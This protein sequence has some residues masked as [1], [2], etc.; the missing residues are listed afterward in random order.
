[1]ITLEQYFMGRDKTYAKELT[2]EYISNAKSL[3]E[4]VNGLLAAYGK[5]PSVNS[6]W[7]PPTVNK[8]VG[9]AL[10]SNHMICRAIDL[11]DDDG[12]LDKWCT[13]NLPLLEKFGL[14]LEHP[15]KTPRW[16]HLQDVRPKSG[17]RVFMP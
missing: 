17:N 9:G 6:G 12:N 7:R 16:C 11:N 4:K 5:F 8:A 2:N 1:M 13:N 10:R 3:L 15:S 14:Y